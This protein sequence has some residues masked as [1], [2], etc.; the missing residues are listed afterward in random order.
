MALKFLID[1][2][3]K[4]REYGTILLGEIERERIER[5]QR[6]RE[7]RHGSGKVDELY[8]RLEVF[9]STHLL[10]TFPLQRANRHLWRENMHERRQ[11]RS[12]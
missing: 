3:I 8:E 4:Q 12:N 2:I 6:Q 5:R 1:R 10:H 9:F 7:M 11:K